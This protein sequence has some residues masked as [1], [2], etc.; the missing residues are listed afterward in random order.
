MTEDISFYSSNDPALSPRPCPISPCRNDMSILSPGSSPSMFIIEKHV[1]LPRLNSHDSTS[2]DSGYSGLQLDSN[3]KFSHSADALASTVFQF[4]EPKRPDIA[5]PS[6]KTPSK[7]SSSYSMNSSGSSR[8]RFSIFHSLSTGSVESGDDDFMMDL[9]TMDEDTQMP[10]DMNSLIS[11]DIKNSTKTPDN[12]RPVSLAR[13]S[14]KLD[15]NVRNSLF[16]SPKTS[17]ITSLITTP[18]RQCLQ[19]ISENV[20][21]PYSQRNASGAFKR[22][23]PPSI[24]PIQSK[25]HK[26]E[27]YPPATADTMKVS[28]MPQFPQRRPTL[29]KSMSMND[30][31][32]MNA[33]SRSSTE[34]NLIGD[35]SR[36]FCLPLIEG[37]H[38][39]LK[40]ISAETLSKLLQGEYIDC[41]ASFKVIDCRYPYEYEGGHIS[42]ALNL[43]THEQILEEFVTNKT[44]PVA[45]AEGKRNILVFHCEF[46]SE[47]G[48]KL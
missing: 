35:F 30:A 46:S 28:S 19:N 48:P 44:E 32:I 5:S 12:K 14:L 3:N 38:T 40:S 47:R 27:N 7:Y 4:V 16:N 25:R 36:P 22:P 13:K 33:L 8:T 39:D 15:V 24:S 18:E 17:T 26:C 2:T 43:Y 41:V 29:R 21:T 20:V 23:E 45:A 42:G 11:K 1:Q 10:F 31:D 6:T 37:D 34:P 9:E